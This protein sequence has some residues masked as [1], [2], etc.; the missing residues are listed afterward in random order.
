M[1]EGQAPEAIDSFEEDLP[2]QDREDVTVHAAMMGT[3]AEAFLASHTG[4]YLASESQRIVDDCATKLLEVDPENVSE[5]RRLQFEAAVAVRA[6]QWVTDLVA[7]GRDA[8]QLLQE[9]SQRN[10]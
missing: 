8:L 6:L 4:K 9:E 2:R 3:D 10:E 5:I 7:I 1:S